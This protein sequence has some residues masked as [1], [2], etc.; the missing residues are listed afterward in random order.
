[1][2]DLSRVMLNYQRVAAIASGYVYVYSIVKLCLCVILMICLYVFV[3][4][5]LGTFT[6]PAPRVKHDWIMLWLHPLQGAWKPKTIVWKASA[7]FRVLP[8]IVC[9]LPTA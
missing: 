1:M 8:S 5:S 7:M 3:R 6:R 9:H 2:V 4:S